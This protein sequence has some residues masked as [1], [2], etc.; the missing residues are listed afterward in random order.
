[1]KLIVGLGNPGPEYTLTRHNAGFIA[2]D[3]LV[4]ALSL[5]QNL[6]FAPNRKFKSLLARYQHLL[7]LKPQTF[8]NLSGQAVITALNFYQIEPK[9][10]FLLHDDLDL[11][12]GEHQLVFAKGPKIHQG[13]NSV[14]ES[15]GTDAFWSGR[16]GVDNRAQ[17]ARFQNPDFKAAYSGKDYVLEPF[18]PAELAQ[19]TASADHLAQ[20]LIK[21]L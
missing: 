18:T 6:E 11:P 4:T 10:L 5:P 12:L 17:D 3:R 19:F 2:L 15:L 9:N 20:S 7:F 1:M 21:E 16:L 8:M 13:V 14:R